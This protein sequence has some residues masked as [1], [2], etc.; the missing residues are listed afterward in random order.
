MAY[1][2]R[3]LTPADAAAYQALRLRSLQEHPEA[4]GASYEDEADRPL[5]VVEERLQQTADS[6][7]L[8]GWQGDAL[9][10]LVGLYRSPR[11]KLRHRAGVGGMY[12]A[13]EA[14]GQGVGTA[15][16]GE[17]VELAPTLDYLEEIILAV[18]VGNVAAR[19]IYRAAG[20]VPAYVEKRYLK[21]D[22]RY[23]DIEW[24]TLQLGS[25]Q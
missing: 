18:T 3:V 17:L 1:R 8:G 25:F 24:M 9:V 21:I 22:G 4:F 16:M 14:R 23:Y 11:V 10:G 19:S 20:F 5:A 7:M 2:I 15:L 6:F 12:V 13:A